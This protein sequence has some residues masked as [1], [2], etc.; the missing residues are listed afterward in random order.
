MDLI[1]LKMHLPK[2][3]FATGSMQWFISAHAKCETHKRAI[4]CWNDYTINTQGQTTVVHRLS[5]AHKQLVETNRHYIRTV[6]EVLL[7][8]A[9]QDLALCG[10]REN[11]V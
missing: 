9:K 7:L 8:C 4:T 10:H 1:D 6:A 11:Y 5:S 2:L 3:D